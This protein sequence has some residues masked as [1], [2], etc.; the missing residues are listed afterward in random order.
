M[1][2]TVYSQIERASKVEIFWQYLSIPLGSRLSEKLDSKLGQTISIFLSQI[3]TSIWMEMVQ[4]KRKLR[5]SK[6]YFCNAPNAV[7]WITH[8]KIFYYCKSGYF[9]FFF[10]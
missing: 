2:L 9:F 4:G 8:A 10:K 1:N 6:H 5:D 7:E 3:I